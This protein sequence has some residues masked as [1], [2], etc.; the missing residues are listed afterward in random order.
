M[1]G[2]LLKIGKQSENVGEE[3]VFGRHGISIRRTPPEAG[4]PPSGNRV[5]PPGRLD[6]RTDGQSYLYWKVPNFM[7]TFPPL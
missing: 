5:L 4:Y 2:I 7:L 3:E 6:R 1:V